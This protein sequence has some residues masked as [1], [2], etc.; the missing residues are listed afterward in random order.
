MYSNY[1]NVALYYT[2]LHDTKITVKVQPHHGQR[3][4]TKPPRVRPNFF[5]AI[6]VSNSEV[7]KNVESLH[8]QVCRMMTI[9]FLFTSCD[10]A[11]KCTLGEPQ[12]GQEAYFRAWV[13]D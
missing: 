10:C 3:S 11:D 13:F 4:K 7:I 1:E 6:R 12:N 8:S 5:L 9:A 2:V